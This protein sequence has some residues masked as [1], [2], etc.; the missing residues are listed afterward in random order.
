M[1]ATRSLNVH[2]VSKFRK[3]PIWFMELLLYKLKKPSLLSFQS[4]HFGVKFKE[5]TSC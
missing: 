2:L 1:Y 3:G 4:L 5:L